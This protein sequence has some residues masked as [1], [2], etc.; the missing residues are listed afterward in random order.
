MDCTRRGN[1][2]APLSVLRLLLPNTYGLVVLSWL[3]EQLGITAVLL[4]WIRL[5]PLVGVPFVPMTCLERCSRCDGCEPQC[6]YD[7]KSSLGN[8]QTVALGAGVCAVA[9]IAPLILEKPGSLEIL[10]LGDIGKY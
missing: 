10:L 1:I 7:E 9:T 4:H 8:A 2:T 5:V 6:G 3:R